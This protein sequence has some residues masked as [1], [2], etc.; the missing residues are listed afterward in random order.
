M[1]ANGTP[2]PQRRLLGELGQFDASGVV[3]QPVTDVVAV[4]AIGV[5]IEYPDAG[6]DAVQRFRDFLPMLTTDLVGIGQ[7]DD[8]A[9][10]EMFGE[11][12]VPR[13]RCTPRLRRGDEAELGEAVAILLALAKINGPR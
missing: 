6:G 4:G 2:L 5:E 1:F 11:R 3:R 7:N 13:S 8:V 9:I 12:I 10:L